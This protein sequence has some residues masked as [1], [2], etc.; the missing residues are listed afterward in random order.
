MY[1]LLDWKSTKGM[2]LMGAYHRSVGS[3]LKEEE[4]NQLLSPYEV[5]PPEAPK[6]LKSGPSGIKKVELNDDEMDTLLS[7]YKQSSPSVSEMNAQQLDALLASY[8]ES[9]VSS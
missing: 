8:K 9:A 1:G 4:I 3:Y 6:T 2:L 5:T 7:P